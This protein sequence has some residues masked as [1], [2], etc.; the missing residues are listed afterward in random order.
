MKKHRAVAYLQG[1]LVIYFFPLFMFALGVCPSW[2]APKDSPWGGDYFPNVLLTDQDG[3]KY[4]FYDDIIKDKVVAINF[5]YTQCADSCPMETANLKRV[6]TLL[7][8]RVGKDIFF[9]SISIDAN[10][11][12]PKALKE[13]AERFKV[14][15]GWKFL[16]GKQADTVL[17]RKKLGMYNSEGEKKLSDHSTSFI[18]GNEST[19]QWIK[20]TPYDEPAKLAHA[21][22]YVLAKTKILPGKALPSYSQVK[23]LPNYSK[24]EELY[25]SRCLACHSLGN[26]NG[27]GPGLAGVTQARDRGWL[28]RW[29]KEPDKMLADKD[30]I[31]MDLYQRFNKVKMPNLRLSE[32]DVEELINF[33]AASSR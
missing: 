10:H 33:L 22:G 13:Y 24:V 5:I 2:A 28:K 23:S 25:Q 20:K 9:Y 15:P 12:N 31:A 29:L 17:L 32:N 30:P 19:G 21:L 4:R 18:I 3:K 16:T 6:Q 1:K 8:E 26:E 11:D 7:G 27:L 14:G